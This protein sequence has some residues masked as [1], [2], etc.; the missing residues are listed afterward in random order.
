MH[1]KVKRRKIYVS[2][3]HFLMSHGKLG[4]KNMDNE[5]SSCSKEIMALK[6]FAR[7]F[8]LMTFR[9]LNSLSQ[10]RKVEA[11]K[12]RKRDTKRDYFCFCGLSAL[13]AFEFYSLITLPFRLWSCKKE[14]KA[15]DFAR[16]GS[17]FRKTFLHM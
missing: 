1:L 2:Q 15:C 8:H 7:I 17:D 6:L 5:F 3:L 13:L 14:K 10:R 16:W 9:T 12:F 4:T 11:K